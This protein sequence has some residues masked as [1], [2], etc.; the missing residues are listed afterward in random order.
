MNREYSQKQT[1]L[2]GV[3]IKVEKTSN[4]TERL[5]YRFNSESKY[6]IKC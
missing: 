3:H 4:G 6:K 1:L 2:V 5:K